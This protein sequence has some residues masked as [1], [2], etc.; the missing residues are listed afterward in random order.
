MAIKIIKDVSGTVAKVEGIDVDSISLNSYTC[1]VSASN[2]GITIFNPNAPNESGQPTK[3]FD[4]VDY[5]NFVKSDGSVPVSA[6]DLK[7]DIDAQLSQVA[8]TDVNV[9][10]KGHW[11]A[12]ANTPDLTGTFENGD[13]FYVGVAGTYESVD[14]DLNDIVKYNGTSFDL[15]PNPNL[16][17]DDIE[18]SAINAY[19][20]VVDADYLGSIKTGSALQPY[21]DL[22]TAIANSSANDSIL[23][24]GSNIISSEIVLPHSLKFVGTQDAEIKY[25]TYDTANGDVMSFEGDNTQ[26]FRFE[27]I[28]FLNAGGYGLYIKK[29]LK[30][31]I[32]DCKFKNNGWDGT[33]LNTVVPSATFGLLG[34]D[35]LQADLQAFYAG[36]HASNGGAMRIQEATQ[37]EIINNNV[38]NNLRGIRL[39]DCGVNGYGFVTRN[40][41]SQNIESGI[42]LAAGSTYYG[43]QN[44]IVTINSSAYNANNGLLCIGGINNKFS[45]NEVNGNW[46]AGMCGWGSANLT[47]RDCGLYDNNRS[48]YNG[49]GNV[50]DAKAS[51]QIND[52]YN[53]TRYSY[54]L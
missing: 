16:R 53:L 22:A 48:T 44:I 13:W 43:C 28:D 34:F 10:Y 50:G 29:T 39:Q 36:S 19:D 3:I 20:I 24:K 11:D 2:G 37:V 25:A 15:I 49:I 54:H 31:V 4:N 35:S 18:G 12:L 30:T 21:T 32:V 23:V 26:E 9:G 47:L 8:P 38:S 51:I 41:S 52:A 45:Q 33:Q 27:N 7:A 6:D 17:V 1:G 46:N 5:T 42:Y 40:V 14:Y